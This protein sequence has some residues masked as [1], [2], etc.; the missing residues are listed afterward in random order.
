MG[1]LQLMARE[2]PYQRDTFE[3][4]LWEVW[5]RDFFRQPVHAQ[6]LEVERQLREHVRALATLVEQVDDRDLRNQLTQMVLTLET[7]AE[8]VSEIAEH[9]Y[10]A[11]VSKVAADESASRRPG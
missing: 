5:N 1:W 11:L 2:N 3:H 4:H 6:L 8:D 7:R 10:L 9:Q